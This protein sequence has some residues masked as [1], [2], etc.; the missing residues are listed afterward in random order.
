MTVIPSRPPRCSSVGL[1]DTWRSTQHAGR[2]QRALVGSRSY[3]PRRETIKFHLS[4]HCVQ[5]MS[6]LRYMATIL[7]SRPPTGS[8]CVIKPDLSP[9]SIKRRW[10]RDAYRPVATEARRRIILYS[11]YTRCRSASQKI[12]RSRWL[13]VVMW[14]AMQ[15]TYVTVTL[16]E[17]RTL[18]GT[19]R[20]DHTI[21][22]TTIT[23]NLRMEARGI[24]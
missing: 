13:R 4:V 9:A 24:Y 6:S 7:N 2:S 14:V 23:L 3:G 17:T 11:I 19:H 15:S 18:D 22:Q 16:E 8:G 5:S 10:W 12:R 20:N 1:S 21:L